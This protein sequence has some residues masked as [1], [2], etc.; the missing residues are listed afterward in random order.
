MTYSK[1]Y[2]TPL[3]QLFLWIFLLDMDIYNLNLLFFAGHQYSVFTRGLIWKSWAKFL[4]MRFLAIE[5]YL[6]KSTILVNISNNLIFAIAKRDKKR[7]FFFSGLQRTH[8]SFQYGLR[9]PACLVLEKLH[10]SN[11]I[12]CLHPPW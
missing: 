9:S 10:F 12:D 4:K 6:N 8:L 3:I 2:L 1:N 7:M 5:F 11:K